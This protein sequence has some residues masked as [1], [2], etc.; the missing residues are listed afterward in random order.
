M[1]FRQVCTNVINSFRYCLPCF[2]ADAA[3]VTEVI[4]DAALSEVNAAGAIPA[5]NTAIADVTLPAIMATDRALEHLENKVANP[6][7][8][9]E[10]PAIENAIDDVKDVSM[11]VANM[12][13][14]HAGEAKYEPAVESAIIAAGDGV[15]IAAARTL[16]FVDLLRQ[17]V[18]TFVTPELT[19]EHTKTPPNTIKYIADLMEKGSGR[20]IGAKY[21]VAEVLI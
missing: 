10:H 19:E 1:T 2:C 11:V 5:A 6:S 4:V 13:L 9:V 16:S 12:A 7:V 14:E 3:I 20:K 15:K 17:D 18:H 21:H 8:L